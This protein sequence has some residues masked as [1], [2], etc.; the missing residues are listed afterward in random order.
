MNESILKSSRNKN[1][2]LNKCGCGTTDST[3]NNSNGGPQF[4]SQDWN[5][6]WL[7]YFDNH[8]SFCIIIFIL[9]VLK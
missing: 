6:P 1:E 5:I 9:N 7:A 2:Q 3:E 4:D 8:L